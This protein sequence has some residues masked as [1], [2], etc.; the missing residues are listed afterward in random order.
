MEGLH[1]QVFSPSSWAELFASW[2]RFPDAVPYAGGTELVLGQGGRNLRLPRNILSLASI[3]ELGRI[4]RTER[5]LEFGAMVKLN[6]ILFLGKIVPE[7]LREA[8]A[9]IANQQVR[10]VAT[11]GGNI[12]CR[13]RRMDAYA[14]LVALDARFE[15][16]TANLSRW[17]AAGRFAPLA[18]EPLFEEQE[19]LS[20][21]RVPLESWDYTLYRRIG[22]LGRLGEDGAA[23]TFIARA[24]KDILSDVRQ[25]FAGAELVRD[26][27]IEN[28]I[29]GKALP[30]SKR[31]AGDFADRWRTRLLGA[32]Y[33]SGLLKSR[34]LNLIEAA[35]N[36]LAE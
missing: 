33:P 16:R 1:N 34:F 6:D 22:G 28:T 5:Y 7:C 36:G 25:A 2:S 9:H 26:R 3:E 19:L 27:V 21:I 10:N 18:G 20:R 11:I 32:A 30:L 4:S 23:F 29:I 24:E 8:I 31:D 35:V 12:C 14:P 17:V 13:G 15:L